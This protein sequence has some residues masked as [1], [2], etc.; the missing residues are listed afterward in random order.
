MPV[1]VV[2]K[3]S[4]ALKIPISKVEELWDKAKSISKEEGRE[5]DWGYVMGIFKKSLGKNKLLKLGW[6][7]STLNYVIVS[8][9]NILNTLSKR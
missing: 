5:N 4:K 9:L 1:G 7:S 2:K 6:Q 8:R 3:V